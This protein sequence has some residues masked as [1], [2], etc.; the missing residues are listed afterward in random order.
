MSEYK[1][2]IAFIA[3]WVLFYF[4]WS[5]CQWDLNSAHWGISARMGLSFFSLTVGVAA[6][7]LVKGFC[8]D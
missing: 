3:V 4:I 1:P 8:D 2:L 6:A 7:A 5:F